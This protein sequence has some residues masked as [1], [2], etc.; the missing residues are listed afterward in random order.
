MRVGT[1]LSYETAE[2]G[3]SFGVVSELVSPNEVV[4]KDQGGDSYRV[5]RGQAHKI[6]NQNSDFCTEL[7]DAV[8]ITEFGPCQ[9]EIFGADVIRQAEGKF[10]QIIHA[11]PKVQHG[12]PVRVV[13]SDINAV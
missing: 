9:K 10:V 1:V 6:Q 13:I 3:P 11:T 12:H 4:A 5:R 7:R 2:R 8:G